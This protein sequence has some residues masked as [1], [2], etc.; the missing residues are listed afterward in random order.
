MQELSIK[1][2]GIIRTPFKEKVEAPRQPAAAIGAKGT[3]ELFPNQR[4]DLA[5]CDLEGWERI[6]VLFWFHLV[7]NWRPK[8][9]PPRSVKR[10]GVFSTRSP[11]RP[12]PIGLSV[13]RLVSVK[14]LTIEVL[15]VDI[16]D[17]S[18]IL[19]IKPY[20]PYADAFPESKVGWLS[21]LA[22][23]TSEGAGSLDPEQ[24]FVVSFS[25]EA[26]AQLEWLQKEHQLE[27]RFP[28]ERALQ[29]G[30][31]PHPYRRIKPDGDA[32]LL[33]YKEWRA[34]FTVSGRSIEVIQIKS[35]YREEQLWTDSS[36]TIHQ[37]FTR[38][39]Y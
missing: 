2:I 39:F 3:I 34:R 31:Q 9:L 36:L 35:G 32:L 24:G 1:P 30:P 22:E 21:P 7:E 37:G 6:W 12:N 29:L 33:A 38:L 8:V 25:Q 13:L 11:H 26:T 5:L 19:D 20:V 23:S 27:L 14:G 18:P 28:I 15:D 17:Q 16:V 10:R 4:Y